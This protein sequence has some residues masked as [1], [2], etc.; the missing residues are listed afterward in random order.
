MSEIEEVAGVVFETLRGA[1]D[2]DDAVIFIDTSGLASS[3]TLRDL[4]K[5]IL[6]TVIVGVAVG[7]VL[8]YGAA[9]FF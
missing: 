5:I 2:A 6:I 9:L 3:F 4:P 8:V 1:M 7:V